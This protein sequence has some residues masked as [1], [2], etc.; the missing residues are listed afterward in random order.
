[1]TWD[2]ANPELDNNRP[3]YTLDD[4]PETWAGHTREQKV[5][6]ILDVVEDLM[7]LVRN[8]KRVESQDA[9]ALALEG[10]MCLTEFYTDAE[11]AAK[12]A[13]HMAEYIEGETATKLAAEAVQA[14]EKRPS[15]VLLKRKALASDEVKEARKTAISLEKEHRKWRCVMDILKDAHVFFRRMSTD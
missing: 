4:M 13:K 3:K 10:Q 2:V 11:A 8:G 5:Q 12:N 1:M 14:G 9:A 6:I 7:R 15:E